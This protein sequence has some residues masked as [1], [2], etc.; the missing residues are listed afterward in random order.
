MS[1]VSYESRPTS[2]QGDISESS[3]TSLSETKH[4]NIF[5][6][7][8]DVCEHVATVMP[9]TGNNS[10]K[11]QRGHSPTTRVLEKRNL[12]L[13]I[14]EHEQTIQQQEEK[15]KQ[16]ADGKNHVTSSID[17]RFERCET[18]VDELLAQ[19]NA[20]ASQ[21]D[22]VNK[23]TQD[24]INQLGQ[25][26]LQLNDGL[27]K[28]L[29]D[30][31]A[32]LESVVT[33]ESNIASQKDAF[34]NAC[35]S[36]SIVETSTHRRNNAGDQDGIAC[37]CSTHD[38][39]QYIQWTEPSTGKAKP[40]GFES[41]T[42]WHFWPLTDIPDDEKHKYIYYGQLVSF[43]D[44]ETVTYD[45][46]ISNPKTLGT[47]TN[48]QLCETGPYGHNQYATIVYTVTHADGKTWLCEASDIEYSDFFVH[49]C[50]PDGSSNHDDTEE[51]ECSDDGECSDDFAVDADSDNCSDDNKWTRGYDDL[52][53]YASDDFY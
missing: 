27:Q 32:L 50:P 21:I 12:E 18:L 23:A 47:V 4:Y 25:V 7:E 49:Y 46:A 9:P 38:D 15:F 20:N 19:Y 16:I 31:R 24:Q 28:S 37:T 34:E 30:N 22:N 39:E 33:L 41:V 52:D 1:S 8:D 17:A 11:T 53:G 51:E 43:Y 3:F 45:D 14:Q 29:E 10:Q 13:R 42:T 6:S 26:I 2:Q 5:S 44:G 40:R 48:V 35:E 36:T